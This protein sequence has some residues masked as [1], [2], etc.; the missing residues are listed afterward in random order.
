MAE[1]KA[2]NQ[3]EVTSVM[4]KEV[5]WD[6]AL[7]DTGLAR[8]VSTV[9]CEA[10]LH[11]LEVVPIDVLDMGHIPPLEVVVVMMIGRRNA[12]VFWQ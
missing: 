5:R 3:V 10:D 4:D 2:R 9:E 7:E 12:T 11:P 6:I 1:P 8:T